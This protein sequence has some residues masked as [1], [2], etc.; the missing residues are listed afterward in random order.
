MVSNSKEHRSFSVQ[1]SKLRKTGRYSL[2][3]SRF[4]DRVRSASVLYLLSAIS[5]M[6]VGLTVA[7]I[8]LLGLIEVIWLTALM[9]ML[10][11]ISTMLGVYIMFDLFSN[12]HEFNSLLKQ[13][14][15]RSIK[16]KN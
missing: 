13:A 6:V 3:F 2:Q 4:V 11:C 7:T 5:Q 1:S 15:Q 12:K 8:A 14:I 9:L 10:G 16:F